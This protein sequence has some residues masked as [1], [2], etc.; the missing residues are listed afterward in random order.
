MRTVLSR[1]SQPT[2]RRRV[3]PWMG[4]AAAVLVTAAGLVTVNAGAAFGDASSPN[5]APPPNCPPAQAPP[6]G[7]PNP[8]SGAFT[9]HG[10]R[11]S[12]QILY[13][14]PFTGTIGSANNAG[15]T[16]T[17][18]STSP[19][20]PTIVVP[21]IYAKVC[22]TVSLPSL[23]GSIPPGAVSL[24]SNDAIN[25][26]TTPLPN[27][28]NVYVGGVEA[29]PLYL[30]FGNLFATVS[31]TPA[32]NGGLDVVVNGSN[33]ATFDATGTPNNPNT[34]GTNCPVTI[35]SVPLT[36]LTSG[37]LVGQPV[38]GPFHGGVALAVANDFAIPA[39]QPSP[40]CPPVI[41][42]T[43]NKFVGLPAAPGTASLTVPITFNFLLDQAPPYDKNLTC[44]PV[45]QPGVPC[46]TS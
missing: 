7:Y 20:Q 36:T 39:V 23:M 35:P 18:K 45:A 3:R 43:V 38:T 25:N 11:F 37:A 16:L 26:D 12:G 10:H 5:G 40:S 17:L 32:H 46:Q 41:A 2:R 6:P 13:K 14:I 9:F 1:R 15:G 4:A 34:L 19:T 31:K 29:F 8:P 42:Q 27:T 30:Q 22:G 28:A 21:H 24:A 33:S 44:P